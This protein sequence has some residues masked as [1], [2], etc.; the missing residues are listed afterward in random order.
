MNANTSAFEHT[1]VTNPFVTNFP[2]PA[3]QPTSFNQFNPT[4]FSGAGAF[5]NASTTLDPSP[6]TGSNAH[7]QPSTVASNSFFPQG[8]E[9]WANNVS[10][11]LTPGSNPSFGSKRSA[12]DGNVNM[13]QPS[14]PVFGAVGGTPNPFNDARTSNVFGG[15][16]MGAN[17]QAESV[18]PSQMSRPIFK[19][20]QSSSRNTLAA[21]NTI[22]ASSSSFATASTVTTVR[23]GKPLFRFPLPGTGGGDSNTTGAASMEPETQF[24][25]RYSLR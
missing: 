8:R 16:T 21:S 3:A 11:T 7:S 14:M 2:Q 19:F 18:P 13:R 12:S 4:G 6:A 9:L 24:S 20:G 25:F 23:Q 17:M 1:S 22:S 5:P 10:N 15:T